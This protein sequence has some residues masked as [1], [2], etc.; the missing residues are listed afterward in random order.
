MSQVSLSY[1]LQGRPE[2]SFGIK[3][4]NEV[5]TR[6]LGTGGPSITY[7]IFGLTY[8][9]SQNLAN[10]PMATGPSAP[11]E[12]SLAGSRSAVPR[13][14]VPSPY[15][16]APSTPPLLSATL[17]RGDVT[18]KERAAGLTGVQPGPVLV[19][20]WTHPSNRENEGTTSCTC[21]IESDTRRQ[22]GVDIL[23]RLLSRVE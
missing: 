10:G 7:S 13:P 8:F 5:P 15:S 4:L 3:N 6:V 19:V 12:G 9:S 11:E 14:H 18:R 16:R 2:G 23:L 17:R 22:K 1:N 21:S 20:R